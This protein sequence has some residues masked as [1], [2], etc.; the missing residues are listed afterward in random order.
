MARY[1]PDCAEKIASGA[2]VCKHCGRKFTDGEV[3]SYIADK[4]R[5][6]L[7]IGVVG[8]VM[9]LALMATCRIDTPKPAVDSSPILAQSVVEDCR[10]LIAQAMRDGVIVSRPSPNR[11]NVND[12]LWASLDAQTKD[13]TMQA[14]ACDL[15]QR[16]MPP[17]FEHV[18]AYG[19]QSGR[20]VQ[21]LTSV[22]MNRE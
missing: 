13:R 12:R 3:A 18:V 14:V 19:N 8:S 4:S 1:C 7:I 11:I 22:G 20:R 2:R 5:N 15:W 9:M 21:M 6:S 17:D 16:D 10:S